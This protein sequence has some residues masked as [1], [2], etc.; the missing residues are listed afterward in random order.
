VTK[1]DLTPAPEEY[2]LCAAYWIDDGIEHVHQPTETG[3][4][5]SGW[6][7]HVVLELISVLGLDRS[8]GRSRNAGFITSH[9]RYV[10]REE[11]R[12]IAIAAGQWRGPSGSRKDNDLFSEELY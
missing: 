5:L 12:K 9:N 10:G 4:V 3:Y 8:H 6:R 2:I 11:G 7:H 1:E